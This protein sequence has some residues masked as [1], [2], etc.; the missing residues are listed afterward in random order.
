MCRFVLPPKWSLGSSKATHLFEACCM[1]TLKLLLLAVN[2]SGLFAKHIGYRWCHKVSHNIARYHMV[3]TWYQQGISHGITRYHMVPQ[4]FTRYHMMSQGI[5]HALYAAGCLRKTRL[6]R[7]IN[8]SSK[9]DPSESKLHHSL[10]GAY[11]VS[12]IS[13]GSHECI[14]TPSLARSLATHCVHMM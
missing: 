3:P 10:R 4:G 14:V 7:G 6:C 8:I 5:R 9:A 1:A 11:R 2:T 12:T 13:S